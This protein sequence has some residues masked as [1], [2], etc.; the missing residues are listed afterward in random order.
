M[1]EEGSEAAAA[2]GFKI[3][4]RMMPPPPLKEHTL[5]N[6]FSFNLRPTWSRP[7]LSLFRIEIE[8]VSEMA[9]FDKK[10]TTLQLF[11]Y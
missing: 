7:A 8:L 11:N 9:T 1:N 10:R 2:T 6:L 5:V 3:T 4:N